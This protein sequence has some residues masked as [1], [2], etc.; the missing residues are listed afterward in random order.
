MPTRTVI[1]RQN[2]AQWLSD[3]IR[4]LIIKNSQQIR[5][6]AKHKT[7]EADRMNFRHMRNYIK[8]KKE[9]EK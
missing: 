7:L 5:R 9:I 3:E 1:V 2:E 6:K 8:S 4:L